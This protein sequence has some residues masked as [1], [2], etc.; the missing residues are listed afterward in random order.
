VAAQIGASVV[1]LSGASLLLQSFRNL[2]HQDLGM[3]TRNVLTVHIPL[4]AQRYPSGQL[5]WTS[6]CGPKM[7]LNISLA[8]IRWA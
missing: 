4:N 8:S 2:E 3:Q 1:L 7:L 5:T 6:I